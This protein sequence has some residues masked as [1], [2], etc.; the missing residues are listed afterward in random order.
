MNRN[1]VE[2]LNKAP[3]SVRQNYEYY[4]IKQHQLTVNKQISKV[5]HNDSA[6]TPTYPR[7]ENDSR[8]ATSTNQNIYAEYRDTVE[9][10][11]SITSAQKVLDTETGYEYSPGEITLDVKDTVP[12]CH[13]LI[14]KKKVGDKY[15]T[16][17]N[18]SVQSKAGTEKTV[19][20]GVSIE[21]TLEYTASLV[22]DERKK[23]EKCDN[24]VTVSNYKNKNNVQAVFVRNV[25]PNATASYYINEYTVDVNNYI[26]TLS[27][28][29]VNAN[30]DMGVTYENV[31]DVDDRN[32]LNNS[33]RQQ[34]PALVEKDDYV[35]FTAEIQNLNC[36]GSYYIEKDKGSSND[37][38]TVVKIKELKEIMPAGL[39]IED[40]SKDITAKDYYGNAVKITIT[41]GDSDSNSKQYNIKIDDDFEVLS[42]QHVEI[43]IKAK[44]TESNLS[45][46]ELENRV[47]LVKFDNVNSQDLTDQNSIT[48]FQYN[49]E[50]LQLK[51]LVISGMVWDDRIGN[52]IYDYSDKLKNNIRVNLYCLYKDENGNEKSALVAYTE[53][54]SGT[55]I[56]Y[57]MKEIEGSEESVYYNSANQASVTT[58][59]DIKDENGN[60]RHPGWY[61]FGRVQKAKKYGNV[62]LDESTWVAKSSSDTS[63]A[64]T[65]YAE[66]SNIYQY[67]IEF[68]YDG[69]KYEPT[70]YS[71][72]K[73]I[74]ES[75]GAINSNYRRDSNA[76]ELPDDRINLNKEYQIIGYNHSY[77]SA[78]DA[79]IPKTADKGNYT[80]E[81]A[82]GTLKKESNGTYSGEELIYTKDGHVSTLNESSSD[83][84]SRK[85]TARSFITGNKTNT[86]FFLNG[87]TKY[88]GYSNTNP[89]TQYLKYIN[90]GLID[91]TKAFDLEVKADV[92]SITTT[93]NGEEMTYK[94]DAKSGN[95]YTTTSSYDTFK[96]Y[97]SDA[98]YK[99]DEY[100]DDETIRAYKDKSSELDA[101]ITYTITIKNNSSKDIDSKVNEIAVYYDS[102]FLQ[103]NQEKTVARKDSD[104]FVKPVTINNSGKV[105]SPSAFRNTAK[106]ANKESSKNGYNVVYITVKKP[107]FKKDESQTVDVTFT[108]KKNSDRNLQ[109]LN[110]GLGHNIIAEISAY[111]TRYGESSNLAGAVAGYIDKDS[112]PGN[113]GEGNS[114]SYNPNDFSEEDFYEDDTYRTGV[115]MKIDNDPDNPPPDNPPPGG[116]SKLSRTITGNVWEDLNKDGMNVN[117]EEAGIGFI[118]VSLIEMIPYK[119]ATGEVR[120]YEQ[121]AKDSSGNP[122]ATVTNTDGNYTLNNFIPGYYTVKFEYGYSDD[123]DMKYNGQD[124]KSTEYYNNDYYSGLYKTDNIGSEQNYEY[125]KKVKE[126]LD[127][128]E[129]SDALDDEIRRLNANSYSET[130]T[131]KE[132]TI[133]SHITNK[134]ANP[135]EKTE[136]QNFTQMYAN[137]TIFYANPENVDAG[138]FEISMS[139]ETTY[140][141]WKLNNLDFGLAQRPL[142]EIDLSKKINNITVKTSDGQT[143]VKLYFDENGQ[144]DESKSINQ[145]NVQYVANQKS[146][147]VMVETGDTQKGF[148]YINMDKDITIGATVEVKY[149]MEAQNA[150][151]EDYVGKNLDDIKYLSECSEKNISPIIL[152]GNYSANATAA[153]QL[154]AEYYSNYKL[155]E[156]DAGQISSIVETYTY[157]KKLK[158]PCVT[159]YSNYYGRYLGLYYY[160]GNAGKNDVQAELKTNKIL[161]LLDNDFVFNQTENSKNN[162]TWMTASTNPK[163]KT[164]IKNLIDMISIKKFASLKPTEDASKYLVFKTYNNELIDKYQVKYQHQ[165]RNN[166]LLSVDTNKNGNATSNG[167]NKNESLSRFLK[168]AA[169]NNNEIAD[170]KGKISLTASKILTSQDVEE[171][172]A[173]EYDNVAEIIEYTNITGRKT[174]L[175]S[176]VGNLK[177]GE[178][179]T[180]G[181]P[182]ITISPPTGLAD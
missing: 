67:Y 97:E 32:G 2:A 138:T 136:V 70:A 177:Y 51:D 143:L 125:F 13:N 61:S 69:L 78:D 121:I 37:Y 124:Y 52:E 80:D 104:G 166:I 49:H 133:F 23:G 112:N 22:V 25:I 40:L 91:R 33:E 142:A 88:Y 119:T 144:I 56:F 29:N 34:K 27:E 149:D 5:N 109:M 151:D 66:Y 132:A 181:P 63:Y 12:L 68:E 100:Y 58:G 123:Y 135:D 81:F 43:T 9:Y 31:F 60:L 131:Q 101:E 175:D 76:A 24:T 162:Q 30:N 42:G 134:T 98:A 102:N 96:I 157:L 94:Y 128:D 28:N 113:L 156:N 152:G 72:T 18:H 4:F 115:Y 108:V 19:E 120:Y 176:S 79:N 170:T 8:G 90:L 48:S 158:K 111:S 41:E 95:Y 75:T 39:E 71:N 169:N 46:K 86:L 116:N 146:K 10:E 171:G 153:N 74:T 137:S 150:S 163:D 118:R 87:K 141:N 14:I 106:F 179:D 44:V 26:S 161:D 103:W 73:N 83:D 53:T 159:D 165:D 16:M 172:T 126:Y 147:E 84:S 93:I 15:T 50:W 54:G 38:A 117:D 173:L 64:P 160:T 57:D 65:E 178:K 99:Y 36:Y 155:T 82:E 140:R 17:V 174:R 59:I 1:K 129:W 35:S 139:G 92:K 145:D 182:T 62:Y 107:F 20:T 77:M 127:N 11:I 167:T 45:L 7:S 154:A 164:Y 47:E 3:N 85:I 89:D 105:S 122:I 130:M 6:K 168:T 148:I 55:V 114:T 110:S 21:G 180:D